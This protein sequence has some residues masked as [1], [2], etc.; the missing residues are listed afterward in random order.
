M[1]V[2][3]VKFGNEVVMSS[4]GTT[5]NENN[6]LYGYTA[7]GSD[8]NLVTGAV[9]THNVVDNLT[10]TSTTDAL[11][12]NQG[13]VLNEKNETL[14]TTVNQNWQGKGYNLIPFPYYY[15]SQTING[16]TWTVNADGSV[17]ANGTATSTSLFR[18][19][20]NQLDLSTLKDG[21]TYA[22][23]A[24]CDS[25]NG[26]I[27]VF[28][29]NS[30]GTVVINGLSFVT[31]EYE[32]TENNTSIEIFVN[33]GVVANNLTFHPMLVEVDS[34]GNYPTEY[35]RY[36]MGNIE[37]TDEVND[38]VLDA[39]KANGYNLIPFPYP[40]TSD[41]NRGITFTSQNDG[42][43][44]AN[45]TVSETTLDAFI[46]ICST[47]NLKAGTY[48]IIDG[49]V[50]SSDTKYWC[51]VYRASSGAEIQRSTR[52]EVFTLSADTDVYIQA[53]V[54]RS[55]T[56]SNL[57]FHPML[58]EVR[59]DGT[60]PTEYKKY[61]SD[62]DHTIEGISGGDAWGEHRAYSVD[63]YVIY[64]NKLYRCKANTT[65]GI[66]PTNTTYWKPVS[67][68]ELSTNLFTLNN[69]VSDIIHTPYLNELGQ[70][71][72]D[73]EITSFYNVAYNNPNIPSIAP[74]K[75]TS[76]GLL[77]TFAHSPAIIFQMLI[78]VAVTNASVNITVTRF[79]YHGTWQSWIKLG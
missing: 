28:R 69:T 18:L 29:P 32:R 22:V 35:Q 40:F 36:A 42:G 14:A 70:N 77:I 5:V 51:T 75:G 55:I 17:T 10:S 4:R 79:R 65:A 46:A 34:N 60:Y 62:T 71:S 76:A 68:K 16:I 61:G 53:R 66:V 39:E 19:S 41:T 45:G 56:V 11:S 9:I 64:Q 63:D 78:P 6:L 44:I 43:I 27:E 47:F 73:I 12:A 7:L 74:W 37:L 50:D 58:V 48:R 13:R 72:L 33:S 31:F 25:N 57:T 30:S 1:G 21:Y 49:V 24:L 38:L 23:S 15:N 8:G 67:I 54:H 52:G 3:E 59:P 2:N 20:S 26:R